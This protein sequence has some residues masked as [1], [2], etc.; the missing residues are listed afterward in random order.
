MFQASPVKKRLIRVVFPCTY[1][2][3]EC[4]LPHTMCV[5]VCVSLEFFKALAFTCLTWTDCDL[6]TSSPADIG[7][8][9]HQAL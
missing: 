3:P 6:L 4:L 2:I 8:S 9:D 5:H 1:I 7:S